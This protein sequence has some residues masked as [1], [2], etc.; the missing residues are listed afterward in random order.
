VDSSAV[1]FGA[2]LITGAIG[3][4]ANAVFF[5]MLGLLFIIIALILVTKEG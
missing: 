5:G 4:M 2:G 3:V 1:Y